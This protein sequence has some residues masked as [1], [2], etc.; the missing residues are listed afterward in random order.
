MEESSKDFCR[1]VLITVIDCSRW[2]VV[3]RPQR[4]E[5]RCADVVAIRLAITHLG[6]G[7]RQPGGKQFRCAAGLLILEK[8]R[9]IAIV[10][11]RYR[12]RVRSP[13]YMTHGTHFERR[14]DHA[15]GVA[16]NDGGVDDFFRGDNN[17]F[18]G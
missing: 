17:M 16:A 14:E 12:R 13:R 15:L 3:S 9:V 11:P 1:T 7:R 2:S 6:N 18:A 4:L 10:I 5:S 8:G